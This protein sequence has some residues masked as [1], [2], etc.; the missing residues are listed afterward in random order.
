MQ[1]VQP[2]SR[3]TD[4]WHV[5]YN[6]T[7]FRDERNQWSFFWHE[8]WGASSPG[9]ERLDLAARADPKTSPHRILEVTQDRVWN[10]LNVLHDSEG[11]ILVREEYILLYDRLSAAF[12]GNEQGAVITGQCGVGKSYFLV[13]ALLRRMG[14]GKSVLF[15]TWFN[16][17]LLFDQYGVRYMH[18]KKEVELD[19][20]PPRD[21]SVSTS[22]AWSL[23]DTSARNTPECSML[24]HRLLFVVFAARLQS[25]RFRD[26]LKRDYALDFIMEPWCVWE[27]ERLL[28]VDG[29]TP[30]GQDKRAQYNLNRK[31]VEQLVQ[32]VG[33]CPRD[34]I[35]SVR[36]PTGYENDV[37]S[38]L[39]GIWSVRDV[40]DLF[41][42]ADRDMTWH[43]SE[44]VVLRRADASVT[45]AMEGHDRPL[46]CFKSR[47]I[48]LRIM[49]QLGYLGID[50]ARELF[51]ANNIWPES[52]ALAHWVFEGLVIRVI[53]GGEPS[54][55]SMSDTVFQTQ[56]PCDHD[57]LPR[58]PIKPR[59]V[60]P[61][62]EDVSTITLD[63]AFCYFPL[64]RDNPVF[65]A[66]FLQVTADTVVVWL[67][68]IAIPRKCVDSHDDAFDM[69]AALLEKARTRFGK[70][71][72]QP[73]YVLVAPYR[74]NQTARWDVARRE[75]KGDVHVYYIDVSTLGGEVDDLL[76]CLPDYAEP[77]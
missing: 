31:N 71:K 66:F 26:W 42:S 35:L 56:Q 76:E 22:R 32:K 8:W 14:E 67:F 17:T 39:S 13:Y 5:L 40:R 43:S 33:P 57:P 52:R 19:Q 30:L 3:Y 53:S 46:I 20:L 68:K 69:L 27:L 16:S 45:D 38:S 58:P 47:N 7:P 6:A 61:A 62:C 74:R 36:S 28:S 60:V 59:K 2:L 73:K 77:A 34:V 4:G 70:P 50:D 72:A 44:L 29:L 49:S 21:R 65:D 41:A 54:M 48:G 63:E 11:R 55:D 24:L 1:P 9:K 10:Q 37:R 15:S 12:E 18:R 23:I 51:K 75:F 25:E 64:R